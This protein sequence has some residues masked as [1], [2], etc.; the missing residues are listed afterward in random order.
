MSTVE[1]TIIR[2][3]NAIDRKEWTTAKEQF[4]D[5]VMVDYSSLNNVPAADISSSDIVGS[6][7]N[8]LASVAT[9]H[10]VS[11][12]EVNIAGDI[13]ESECHVYACHAARDIED[14]DCY[15]RYLH[16]LERIRG[17]WQITRMTLVVHGQKGNLSFLQQIQM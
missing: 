6:W 7:Q 16:T 11:N 8:L 1:Q 12:V 14:W 17:Q 15:G 3:I 10:M 9:P 4:A 13:A 2:M 5:T